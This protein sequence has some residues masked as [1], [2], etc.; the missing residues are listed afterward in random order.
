MFGT[1][2]LL[3]V[4]L[5]LDR[6]QADG[7]T[8]RVAVAGDW[9]T[10]KVVSNDGHGL[11]VKEETGEVCVIRTEAVSAVRLLPET[12]THIPTQPTDARPH[13]GPRADQY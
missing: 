8:V 9:I 6:A 13:P 1:T 3:T 2:M 4:G 10:G 11:V 7:L 5:A 12:G